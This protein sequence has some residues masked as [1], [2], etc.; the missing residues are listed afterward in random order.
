M[1]RPPRDMDEKLISRYT[2]FR[3]VY[4]GFSIT[5][6]SFVITH[7]FSDEY[8]RQTLLIN[9]IVFCQALYMLNCRSIL[10][11]CLTINFLKNK[12]LIISLVVMSILQLLM[13]YFKLMNE[14]LQTVPLTINQLAV[15]VLP[16]VILFLIIEA[17]KSC[18]RKMTIK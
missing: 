17:E 12:T 1:K 15:S 4:V 8:V 16:S 2:L 5:L 6:I 3:I 18:I 14:M 13:T 9:S 10:G 7:I 11:S